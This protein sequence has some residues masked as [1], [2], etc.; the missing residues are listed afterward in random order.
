MLRTAIGCSI[1]ILKGLQRIAKVAA[2][3]LFA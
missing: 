2:L 1:F 3:F